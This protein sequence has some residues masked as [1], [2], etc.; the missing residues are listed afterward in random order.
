MKN[1]FLLFVGIALLS[2][3]CATGPTGPSATMIESEVISAQT[4]DYSIEGARKD[5]LY[6]RARNY[7]A[8][9]FGDSRSV[10]RIEDKDE[11]LILGKGATSWRIETG[12]WAVPHLDCYSEYDLR[13]MAKDNRAR[14]QLTLLEGAPSFSQCSGWPRPTVTG[15]EKILRG[16]ED[17]SQ[18][19][20]L[21]LKG[22][23]SVSDFKDF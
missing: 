16:F 1:F 6:Q 4:Y 7:F 14:L 19:L 11:G 20:E 2:S 5:D 18:R 17:F 22:E 3:G 13:F 12:N 23:G 15:Y 10:I 8:I 9:S 21:E